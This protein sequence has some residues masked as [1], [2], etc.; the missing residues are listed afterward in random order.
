MSKLFI[1]HNSQNNDFV[2][3]LQQALGDLAQDVWATPC[4]PGSGR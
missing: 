2:R 3:R 1:S 4:W